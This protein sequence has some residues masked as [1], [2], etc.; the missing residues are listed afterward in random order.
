MLLAKVQT[1]KKKKIFEIRNCWVVQHNDTKARFIVYIDN[2]PYNL[3]VATFL[4][5][6]SESVFL[7]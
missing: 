4:N 3:Y 2:F 7:L 5:R 6:Y 1:L